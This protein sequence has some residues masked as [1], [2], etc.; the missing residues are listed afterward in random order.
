MISI[1][2]GQTVVPPPLVV[3]WTRTVDQDY[4]L[5]RLQ[6]PA[7]VVHPHHLLAEEDHMSGVRITPYVSAYESM[8]GEGRGE[9]GG[10]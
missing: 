1:R 10:V 9:E 6:R 7:S 3:I 2:A 4:R 8:K 5:L